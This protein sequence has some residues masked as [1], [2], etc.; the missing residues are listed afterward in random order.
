MGKF[1]VWFGKVSEK[2]SQIE[3]DLKKR[4]NGKFSWGL[5]VLLIAG[6]YAVYQIV[7]VVYYFFG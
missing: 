2:A 1:G 4:T 6:L 7:M 5:A 3:N